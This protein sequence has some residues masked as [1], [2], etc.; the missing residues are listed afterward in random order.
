MQNYC[1]ACPRDNVTIASRLRPKQKTAPEQQELIP[2]TE[3]APATPLE[4]I[5]IEKNLNSL[6]FFTPSHKGL[7]NKK[8]KS[9]T[10]SR[11]D[12]G[13]QDAGESHHLSRHLITA[14][15][16]RPTRTSISPSRKS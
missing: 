4:V 2:R 13:P 8:S 3:A 14:C 5:K 12:R 1:C 10:I 15:L 9:I 11:E 16:P 6:G 7:D